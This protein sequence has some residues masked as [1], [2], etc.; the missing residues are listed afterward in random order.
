MVPHPNSVG[1]TFAVYAQGIWS[2]PV[3]ERARK[4]QADR[5][6]LDANGGGMGPELLGRPYLQGGECDDI[7]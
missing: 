3:L 5:L 7:E 4:V 2:R 6:V 1:I